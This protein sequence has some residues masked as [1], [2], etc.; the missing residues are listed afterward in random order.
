MSKG[1]VDI[2]TKL[3]AKSPGQKVLLDFENPVECEIV[4]ID[5]DKAILEIY[6]GSVKAVG[7]PKD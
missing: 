2:L 3:F 4:A 1:M 5:G 6:L 7:I